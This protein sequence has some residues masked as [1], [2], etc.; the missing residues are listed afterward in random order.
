LDSLKGS[1]GMTSDVAAA[2]PDCLPRF[3]GSFP[4]GVFI[5]TARHHF[6]RLP[7]RGG[8]VE[9]KSCSFIGVS[10]H[11]VKPGGPERKRR[12]LSVFQGN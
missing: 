4:A 6:F 7:P 9:S 5:F 11:K 12:S 1:N 2:H 8:A 3:L 10:E